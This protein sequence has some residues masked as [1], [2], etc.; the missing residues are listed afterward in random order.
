MALRL[1]LMTFKLL[2]K[3]EAMKEWDRLDAAIR[4]LLLLC[5]LLSLPGWCMAA[6][7]QVI[8]EEKLQL[9]SVQADFTQEKH[10]PILSKPI[11]SKGVL[12]FQAPAS[13]RWQYFSPVQSLLLMDKHSSRKFVEQNGS[14]VE[15]QA[16]GMDTMQ[17]I[18]QEISSWLSGRFEDSPAFI[19]EFLNKQI[20]LTPRQEGLARLI[21]RIVLVPGEDNG[22]MQSVTI[23]EGPDSFTRI[24]FSNIRINQ[25]IPAGL[26]TQP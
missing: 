15:S 24:V 12:V 16:M 22:V 20:V 4:K 8:A 9:K 3:K 19:T 11:I 1:I 21:S 14:L 23:H 26:F 7:Q 5:W 18:S 6:E 25:K 10:L 17:M 13:L 2:F